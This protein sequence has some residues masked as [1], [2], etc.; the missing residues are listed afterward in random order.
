MTGNQWG[1]DWGPRGSSPCTITDCDRP[2]EARGWCS[3]HYQRWRNNG[4]PLALRGRPKGPRHYK[5]GGDAVDYPAI[6]RR[7]REQKEHAQCAHASEECDGRL[8]WALIIGRG[9]RVSDSGLPY[10]PNIDEDYMSLC[11]LH[12][13]R[14]DGNGRG[15]EE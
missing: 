6:H 9:T 2:M 11:V 3:R 15:G 8:E 12:H 1:T 10:S 4:D 5:W 13:R 14:Y 7:L